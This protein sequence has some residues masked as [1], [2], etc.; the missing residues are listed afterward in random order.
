MTHDQIIALFEQ[1][2]SMHAQVKRSMPV[3]MRAHLSLELRDDGFP[4]N[5]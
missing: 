3:N 5:R 4:R 2:A 1:L